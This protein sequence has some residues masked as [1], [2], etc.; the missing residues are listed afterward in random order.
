MANTQRSKTRGG[1]SAESRTADMSNRVTGAVNEGY[2]QVRGCVTEYPASSIFT[3]FAV[4]FGVGMLVGCALSG[5]SQPSSTWY[6]R[7][8]AEKFGR[9][10]LDSLSGMV[11]DAVASRLHS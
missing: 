3:L 6:D 10:I 2:D 11:P 5:S 1:R 9:R 8:H 7:A 4:G